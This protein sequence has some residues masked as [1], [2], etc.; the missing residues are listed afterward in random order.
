MA[1]AL[2][3]AGSIVWSLCA[4]HRNLEAEAIRKQG[5]PATLSE[6]DA[7]YPAVPPSENAALV[8]TNAFDL[9]AA[10]GVSSNGA[11]FLNASCPGQGQRLTAEDKRELAELLATNQAALRLL[12][13]APA[14]GRSR[15]P[16]DLRD[17]LWV[18]LPHLGRLKMTVSLLGAEA[19]LRASEGDAEKAAEALLAAGRAADSVSEEPLLISYLVRV[20]A[21]KILLARLE[22]ALGLT[23]WT[24]EQ[25][26]LLEK[27]VGEAERALAL[28]RAFAGERACGIAVFA[29]PNAFGG[30]QSSDPRRHTLGGADL[31]FGLY[32]ASGLRQEDEGYYL[33]AMAKM[34][35]SAELPYPARFNGLQRAGTM[36]TNT[37]GRF[38]FISRMMLP[39]L[40]GMQV[41]DADVTARI[42]AATTA[43]AVER[44]RRAHGDALPDTLEALVPAYLRAVPSDPFDGKPL[45][46]TKHGP[47]YAVYAVG[48]DCK[49]DGGV[50]WTSSPIKNPLDIVFMVEH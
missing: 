3:L 12:R 4:P 27:R 44:F 15:Y 38:C 9:L 48:S 11:R 19:L 47:S 6:L 5:Y 18:P 32:R 45:R 8:Y 40:A 30:H 28:A 37:P 46:F 42:R 2:A 35:T 22:Q 41:R 10:S 23:Q 36:L 25:L 29:D 13:S 31:L 43:L 17:G 50:D 26:A 14:S 7:W 16:I 49:D 39:G 20:A 24:E 1:V 33:G 21:W 34:M